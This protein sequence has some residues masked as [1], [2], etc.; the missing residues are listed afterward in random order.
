MTCH[1]TVTILGYIF[2][3]TPRLSGKVSDVAGTGL[4]LAGS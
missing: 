3:I 4:K 1:Q 2:S